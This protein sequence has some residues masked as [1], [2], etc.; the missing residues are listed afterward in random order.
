MQTRREQAAGSPLGRVID[1]SDGPLLVLAMVAVALYLAQVGG[2]VALLGLQSAYRVVALVIDLVFL[3]DLLLKV[4][5]LR[6]PYL[7]SP[8]FA[9]DLVSA[10]PVLGSLPRVPGSVEALRFVRALRFFRILRTIRLVRVLG[11]FR[12]AAERVG[13]TPEGLAFNRALFLSVFVYTGLFLAVL[14]LVGPDPQAEFHLVLGSV[15]GMLLILVVTRYKVRD[16]SA[17]QMRALLN[18]A[19]PGQVAKHFVA[20]PEA[21]DRTVHMPATVVFCDLTGFTE[22]VEGLSGDLVQ[23][24]AHLEAAFDVVVAEHIA[25]DLIVDKFIGDAVMSFRGGDLVAGSAQD[26]ACRVVRAAVDGAAALVA[27]DDPYFRRLKIGGASAEAAII[28]AF[29]TSSRLSYTILG[30]D[31]NL[32]SRLEAACGQVGTTTLFCPRTRSLAGDAAGISWRRV[33]RLRVKG[34]AEPIE[35]YEALDTTAACTERWLPLFEAALRHFEAGDFAAAQDAFARTDQTR[36][37]G[38]EPSQLYI[39]RCQA[40]LANPPPA[41]W[42]PVIR[43]HK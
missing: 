41:G 19:L 35:V 21:Y 13:D 37:G 17:Q 43:V 16:L 36:V 9:V 14:A 4:A 12:V 18:I 30:D 29:G 33:G 26:H 27:L 31:V 23:L 22:A 15:L 42:Q 10:M 5:V 38:D 34:K 8:W 7:R 32:A 39:A 3:A 1:A 40:L 25:Q 6:G 11:I 28:G 20:N 24:K 2:L